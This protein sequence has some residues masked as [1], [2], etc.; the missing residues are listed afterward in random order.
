MEKDTA[1]MITAGRETIQIPLLTM[2]KGWLVVQK[3]AGISVHNES[4][5]EFCSF[6]SD[7]IQKETT[8]RGRMDMDPD[9]SVHPVH[10]FGKE[11][12][13]AMLLA[14]NREMFRFSSNQ[15]EARQVKTRYI[16]ILHG[17]LENPE[18]RDSWGSWPSEGRVRE[19]TI[20]HMA[21]DA[22]EASCPV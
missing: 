6:A 12:S 9:F 5:R 4:G 20:R 8:L 2:G 19:V 18:G 3:P 17:R 14:V 21:G 16:A 1:Q 15:F 11:T 10:R 7:F 22:I 13:G